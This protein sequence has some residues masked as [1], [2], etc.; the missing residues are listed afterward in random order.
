MTNTSSRGRFLWHELMTTDSKSAEEFYSKVVGWTTQPWEQ[1]PTY[2]MWKSGERSTGGLMAQ[3]VVN[4][5]GPA[6]QWFCY[7]GTPDVDTTVKQTI[8]LGGKIMRPPIDLAK[9]GRFAFLSDPQGAPFAVLTPAGSSGERPGE[10]KLGDFSWHELLTT[11][12]QAA[13]DFYFRLFA[14]EKTGAMDMGGGNMYQ[15]FGL[16]GV[17]FG[18]MFTA[19]NN[20]K[21]PYWLPYALVRDSKKAAEAIKQLGGTVINGP[22]EVP[23]GD[24]IVAGLDRQGATFAVH[25]KAAAA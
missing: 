19:A 7:I 18:G 12:V 13:W 17:P 3:R 5:A 4:G 1:D 21:P 15:M 24:W 14:W 22:M 11:N 20:P 16:G 8:N 9:V 10:P 2:T 25:S 23:G 6:P